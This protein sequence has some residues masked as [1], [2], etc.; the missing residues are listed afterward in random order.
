MGSTWSKVDVATG[1]SKHIALLTKSLLEFHHNC[2]W[3]QSRNYICFHV[4]VNEQQLLESLNTRGQDTIIVEG[5]SDV[6]GD[7]GDEQNKSFPTSSLKSYQEVLESMQNIKLFFIQCRKCSLANDFF[8]LAGEQEIT[9]KHT[10]EVL[11][12]KIEL[13]M[14]FSYKVSLP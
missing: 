9:P 5:D 1:F 8:L 11:C 6:N 12:H 4:E 7:G 2:T 10:R 3:S 13:F 14:C